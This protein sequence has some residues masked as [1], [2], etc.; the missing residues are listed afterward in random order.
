MTNPNY[1][2]IAAVVDR[3]GSMMRCANDMIGGL[4]SFFAEQA[5]LDGTCLVDYAQFDDDY[6]LVFENKPVDTARA[7]LQ[8]RGLTALLDAVGKTVTTLGEKLAGMDEDSRPG[9]VLVVIVT[10]GVENASTDWTY[11]SVKELIE[12]QTD[13][14][15]WDFV[16]L[17]ANIDAPEVGAKFGI[18]YDKAMTFNTGKAGQ[19]MS[20]LSTYTTSYRGGKDAK[21]T[22]D[23]R[24]SV[25]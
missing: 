24:S 19:T 20:S 2:H 22:E 1:T 12:R 23:D 9:K 16:F 13:E 17:G 5:K 21:F 3:S 8:P 18:Q 15:Q 6:E 10:D 25:L 4:D 7:T 14:Y 11:D